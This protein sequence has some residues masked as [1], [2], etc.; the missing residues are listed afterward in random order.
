MENSVRTHTHL[1]SIDSRPQ[2]KLLRM[3]APPL[4]TGSSLANILKQQVSRLDKNETRRYKAAT[5][6]EQN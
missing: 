3:A 5:K 1:P 6:I 4:L 2:P